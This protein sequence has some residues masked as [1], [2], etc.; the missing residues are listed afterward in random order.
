[1]KNNTKKALYIVGT[2]CVI[3]TF[4]IFFIFFGKSQDDIINIIVGVVAIISGIGSLLVGI[5]SIFSTSLDN[6]REYFST[7]DTVAMEKARSILYNYRYIKI[8]YGKTIYDEDFDQFA[9]QQEI[10]EHPML[11]TTNKEEIL[12]AAETTLDFFQMWGL[13]QGKGFLPMWVF[14]T[15][16][17]YSILKLHQAVEDILTEKRKTNPFYGQQ[18]SFLCDRIKK[19]YKKVILQC[20]ESEKLYIAQNLDIKSINLETILK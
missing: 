9:Q 12:S 3:I 18:F 11:R 15:A 10:Q 5:S 19:K 1:M 8:K 7:G 20:I 14:E 13:L 16:S 4:S 17:G 2:L 6:V